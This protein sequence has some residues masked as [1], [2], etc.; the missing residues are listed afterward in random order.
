MNSYPWKSN[1][2]YRKHPELYKIGKGEQGVLIC[3]PYKSEIL[4]YWRFRTPLLAKKSASIIYKMFLSYLSHN[5][6][7]G[8]DMARK[9]LQM[10]F[11]RSKRYAN[12]KGGRKYSHSGKKLPRGTGDPLKL[13]SAEAFYKMW[14]KAMQH[15]KYVKM[16]KEVTEQ[17]Q[18]PQN[19]FG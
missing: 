8:A 6:F 3:E 9:Y 12:Y 1:I 2:N 5:D 4:P 14:K 16:K 10:G 7:V 15:K 11:T 19:I 13:I 17:L 18:H